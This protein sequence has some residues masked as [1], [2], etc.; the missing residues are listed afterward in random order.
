MKQQCQIVLLVFIVLGFIKMLYIDCNGSPER[1]PTGFKGVISSIVSIALIL[2]MY[3][4][5]GL[6]STFTDK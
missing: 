4:G 2:A 5:A 6:F 3:Y 1:K